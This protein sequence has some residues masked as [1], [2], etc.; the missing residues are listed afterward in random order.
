MLHTSGVSAGNEVGEAAT[1][2]GAGVP[3]DLGGTTVVHGRGPDGED[4][5]LSGEGAIIDKGLMLVHTGVERDI[6]ILAPATQ[7][8]EEEDGVLVS[9]LDELFTGVLEEENVTIVEGVADLEA[10]NSVSVT[11]LD[12]FDDLTGGESVLVHAVVE[13]DTLEE[14]GALSGDEPVA[15]GADGLGLGVL[16]GE[17]AE[18]TGADLFLSVF[19]EGGLVHNSEDLISV[20]GRAL[21]SDG[22]LAFHSSLLL[23]SDVLGDRNREEVTFAVG[24]GDGLHVHGLEE[25]HFVHEASQGVGPT[26]RDGLEVLDLVD[27]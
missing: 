7:G 27:I 14:A 11:F 24:I 15:L 26:F 8:V 12:L 16:G 19:E 6:V 20:D 4:D 23:V 5:M 18:G 9:L 10:V 13:S 21:K 25:L 17:A 1:D 22:G 3:Q 2:T